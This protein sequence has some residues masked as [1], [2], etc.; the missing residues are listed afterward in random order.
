[1]PYLRNANAKV[2]P[3]DAQRVGQAILGLVGEARKE[4]PA[5]LAQ[6]E[7]LSQAMALRRQAAVMRAFESADGMR[8]LAQN[9][10]EPVKKR[11]DYKSITGNAVVREQVNPGEPLVYDPDFPQAVATTIGEDGATIMTEMVATRI[12]INAF[13]MGSVV[14]VPWAQLTERRFKSVIRARERLAEALAIKYDLLNLAAMATQA[15]AGGTT[16]QALLGRLTKRGLALALGQ[17]RR[18]RVPPGG[19]YTSVAGMTDI[20]T[21]NRDDFTPSYMEEVLNTGYLG[22]LWG[23]PIY[24]TDQLADGYLFL[25][26]IPQL[27]AWNPIRKDLTIVLADEP[28]QFWLGFVGY[29]RMGLT[30][31]NQFAVCRVTWNPTAA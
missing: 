13:D 4:A 25:T 2:D 20:L 3:Q 6:K 23:I 22:S 19:I 18:N 28:S 14:K 21:F 17:L 7:K 8:R 31:H 5:S 15:A 16:P 12:T 1:M 11:L 9:L 10:E 27:T 26:G 30:W 29:M 24:V